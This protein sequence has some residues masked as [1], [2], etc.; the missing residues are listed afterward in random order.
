MQGASPEARD[1]A[2]DPP[3]LRFQSSWSSVAATE[4]TVLVPDGRNET[5]RHKVKSSI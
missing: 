3:A 2:R 1:R 5:N 4:L